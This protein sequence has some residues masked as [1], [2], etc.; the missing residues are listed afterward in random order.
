M[1]DFI[2]LADVYVT[3][4]QTLKDL[5]ERNLFTHETYIREDTFSYEDG[6]EKARIYF[7]SE[8]DVDIFNTHFTN[9]FA[10]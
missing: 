6:R 4:L 1:T 8:K 3:D 5:R 2:E 10:Q 7:S 9:V